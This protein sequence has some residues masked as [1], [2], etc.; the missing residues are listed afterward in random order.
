MKKECKSM[1][2][3]K[4]SLKYPVGTIWPLKDLKLKL[5]YVIALRFVLVSP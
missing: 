2:S 4:K 3:K 1:Y 5:N